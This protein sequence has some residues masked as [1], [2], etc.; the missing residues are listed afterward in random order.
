MLIDIYVTV[1]NLAMAKDHKP[2][3]LMSLG[4]NSGGQFHLAI[5]GD[6]KGPQT[7]HVAGCHGGLILSRWHQV[8]FS[9]RTQSSWNPN[10]PRRFNEL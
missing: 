8:G 4:L 7:N 2:S 10:S 1:S 9:K 5:H 6:P 3:G